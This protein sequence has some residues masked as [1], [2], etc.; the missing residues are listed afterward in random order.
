MPAYLSIEALTV[1]YGAR[2]VLDR[3]SLGVE[4]GEMIALLGSS[5]CGKTTLLRSIAGFVIPESGAILV[6]GKDITRLPPEARETAMMFQSYALWPHMSV[7]DNI[8]YGLRMR[9]WKKDAIAARIDE[10]LALLQLEG[11]GPRPVTQLSGGQ[12]QRVALG[13]ALAVNPSLLLLDE[14]MSNLDYKVRLELRHEL[15]ALQQRIGITAVYVTHDR[16]EALTLADRIAVIDAGRIVQIGAPEQIFHQPSSAFVAGFMG[17]DN[18]LDLV[19]TENGGLA[20]VTNGV[21][22]EQRIRA[23]FRSDAARLD[24]APPAEDDLVFTGTVA[25]SVYVGQGYRYRVRAGPGDA[26]AQKIYEKLSAQQKAGNNEWDIDVAVIHQ[27]ASAT[28]VNEKLLMPYRN[29]VS[30]GKLVSRDTAKNAL[31]ANVDGYVLPMFHSQIVFAYNP[32]LVKSP[33]KSFQELNEWVKKNPKQF[34]YNGVKGG[35]SGVGFVMGWVAANSGMGDKLEKGPYDPAQ[36]AAI[37]KALTGLKEF[38]QYVVMTPGNAGTLDMLNRGE[39]AIGPVWVDMFYTWQADG[40]MS[41]KIKL[42]LPSPGLPGQPIYY[43]S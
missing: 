15:R 43:V 42:E 24:G 13:R 31:G 8:G 23:H 37:D 16:E 41:P 27:L 32:D 35:M 5:G 11:F 28:M 26:G 33:P 21:P 4:R 9:A 17:A 1:S 30:A 6:D 18:A 14:P 39:S 7:A 38:N 19:R 22:P 25:Q 20:T 36:K 40:K 2:P 3:V 29:D 34:G 12:R 10:M